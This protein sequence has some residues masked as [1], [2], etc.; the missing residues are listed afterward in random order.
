MTTI[1]E[2]GRPEPPLDADEI[3]SVLELL[4]SQRA[5]PAWKCAGLGADGLRA[6]TASSM[7]LGGLLKHMA[8][9]EDHWFSRWLHGRDPSPPWDTVDWE[10]DRDWEWTSA[11]TDSPDEL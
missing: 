6:T 8:F 4:E 1:D 3:G 9:V 10:A 7:T 5:T 11:T 2:Q